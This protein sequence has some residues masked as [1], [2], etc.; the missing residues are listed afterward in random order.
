[1]VKKV[2]FH[3]FPELGVGERQAWRLEKAGKAGF[4][5]ARGR[6]PLQIGR[7][8]FLNDFSDGPIFAGGGDFE[9]PVNL[10]FHLGSQFDFH[11]FNFIRVRSNIGF[12]ITAK[13]NLFFLLF[14]EK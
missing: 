4:A 10:L 1:L 12:F 2:G 6:L 13:I 11:G 7:D 5:S 3:R 14:Q 8:G 9:V